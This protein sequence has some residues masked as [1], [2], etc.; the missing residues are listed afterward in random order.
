MPHLDLTDEE[1]A[2][3][4]PLINKALDTDRYSIRP[5]SS[6]ASGWRVPP[7]AAGKAI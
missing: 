5:S 1:R 6:G 4:L 3:L 7:A 2:A